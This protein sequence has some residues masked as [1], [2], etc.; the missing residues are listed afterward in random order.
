MAV[1]IKMIEINLIYT[2]RGNYFVENFD[3]KRGNIL[4]RNNT[5]LTANLLTSHISVNSKAVY[6][7][8][9]FINKV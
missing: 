5:S 6:D 8:K 2:E 4:D 7:K 9:K 1:T 3:I